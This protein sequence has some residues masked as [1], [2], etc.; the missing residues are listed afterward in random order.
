MI[1]LGLCFI[2]Y[3]YYEANKIIEQYNNN[4]NNNKNKNID[5]VDIVVSMTTMPKRLQSDAFKI[6]IFSILQS[7]PPPKALFLNIPEKLKKTNESYVI[8]NWLTDLSQ[9]ENNPTKLVIQRCEDEGPA[10]KYLPTLRYFTEQ[11]QMNQLIF[12]YD[13]DSIIH[14]DT[15]QI[16]FQAKMTLPDAVICVESG[17]LSYENDKLY[18]SRFINGMNVN[19]P[20]PA[21]I[22]LGHN[23]YCIQPKMFTDI[24]TDLCNWDTW[25]SAAFFVDDIVMSAALARNHISRIVYPGLHTKQLTH[26]T[27][28]K[29]V[30]DNI[31]NNDKESL[32][33]YMNKDGSNDTITIQY[34]LQDFITCMSHY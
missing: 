22:V 15:F 34:F 23:G 12:I 28:W 18:I 14:P 9:K 19:N 17:I 4:N 33:S 20:S 29:M 3:D 7:S 5:P 31:F 27:Y 10:T 24:K 25:P 32:S 16:C 8:P 2:P 30:R 11:Q 26:D 21:D 13:D 1:F 6:C